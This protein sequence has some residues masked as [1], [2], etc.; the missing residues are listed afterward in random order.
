M[1]N[2]EILGYIRLENKDIDANDIIQ[3]E[4][5][6]ADGVFLADDSM[7]LDEER[8]IKLIKAVNEKSDM[9][10]IVKRHYQRLEDVKKIL[11]AGD[12]R[13][14]MDVMS[15]ADFRLMSEVSD[16]FGKEKI[17]A[18]IPSTQFLTNALASAVVENGAG[19]CVIENQGI[20]PFNAYSL[21]LFPVC[22][23]IQPETAASLFARENVCGIISSEFVSGQADPMALKYD[24]RHQGIQT[25]CF[26][27]SL[28][29]SE[30]KLNSDGLIP[31][32]TQEYKTGKVLMLAYMNEEAF[33]E[34]I[35]SGRMTYWSRSRQELWK[36]GDTSGHYQ[37][38]KSLDI[39][40]DKDTLLAKVVQI[41]AACHT[42]NE[43]CFYTNLV[44]KN[45]DTT[46][47]MTIFD[48]VM[49][50]ILHRRENPKEGSYTNYLFDKG[51]DKILKKVGEEATEIVIAAKNPDSDELKYEICDFLYH[52]MV[53]M[54]ERDVSW[55]EITK[56]LASRH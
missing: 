44:S 39:D 8:L 52:M 28:P 20:E 45:Y 25:N 11:Y 9:P 7:P 21:P 56:E 46:N 3:L 54:A 6:G 12:T 27:S 47:P 14:A 31:V 42:G 22:S 53:L 34:T 5:I 16:R 18:W 19:A 1:S 26:E 35:R 50:T 4:N 33:N 24:L 41:G 49:E 13:V 55:K 30:F 2:K 23:H 51:I 40:C 10:L 36:K 37:Y 17:F 32:I 38:V 15:A 29:F 48:Q 43:S